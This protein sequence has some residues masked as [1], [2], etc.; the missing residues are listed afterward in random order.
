MGVEVDWRDMK[1]LVPAS[2]TLGTFT[3]ALVKNIRD[4]SIEHAESLSRQGQP[5]LFPS[6]PKPLKSMY[7]KMQQVHPKTL[8]CSVIAKAKKDTDVKFRLLCA[9][10]DAAGEKGAPLHLKIKAMHDDVKRGAKSNVFPMVDIAHM[11]MPRQWYLKH[12]DPDGKRTLDEVYEEVHE[13]STLYYNLVVMRK[14]EGRYDFPSAL[15]IYESFVWISRRT[16][17]GKYPAGCVCRDSSTNCLCD[18][19]LLTC[20]AFDETVQVPTNLVAETPELRKKVNHLRGTAGPRRA[21]LIVARAKE[22]QKSASKLSYMDSPIGPETQP[23]P[24][25]SKLVIPP[26]VMPPS[27]PSSQSSEELVVRIGFKLLYRLLTITF[28]T[29]GA[30]TWRLFPQEAQGCFRSCRRSYCA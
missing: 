26:A 22:Q 25:K 20:A 7:D 9:T 15:D 24:V 27:S 19:V 23:Q 29:G 6:V 18:H 8:S 5:N 10:I 28:S 14:D 1:T 4:L 12:I 11:L 13:R 17:W 16:S 2:A 21:A 3:G 30:R